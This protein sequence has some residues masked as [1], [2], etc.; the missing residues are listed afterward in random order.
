MARAFFCFEAKVF[1]LHVYP[2]CGNA[3]S[4]TFFCLDAK[5]FSCLLTFFFAVKSLLLLSFALMQGSFSLFTFF[6]LQKESDKEKEAS[7]SIAPPNQKLALRCR[8][9]YYGTH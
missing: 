7:D 1:F 5:L 3:V 2:F 9:S 8:D 4:Y 6:L